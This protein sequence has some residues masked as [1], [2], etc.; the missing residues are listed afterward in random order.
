MDTLPPGAI[1]IV[2]AVI[3][4]FTGGL[5]V[6]MLSYLGRDG[7]SRTV[8]IDTSSHSDEQALLRV[9]RVKEELVIFV[10]GQRYHH[11]RAINDSQAGRDAVEAIKAVLT[12]AEGWLPT[13]QQQASPQLASKVSPRED[14]SLEH[15]RQSKPFASGASASSPLM[16]PLAVVKEIDE[17]VQEKLEARP[18]LVHRQIRLTTDINGDLLIYVGRQSF[19][20]ASDISDP[21][22]R[23]LIQDA[24]REWE[25]R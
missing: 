3:S 17:L 12:F 1:I 10:H 24:I 21:K 9:S 19:R 6:W 20:S 11:L 2:V 16:T 23:N 15:L 14:G 7:G 25:S 8:K 18:D 22:A 4:A 5:L 13:L